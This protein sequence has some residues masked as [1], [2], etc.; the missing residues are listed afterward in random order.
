MDMT[1]LKSMYAHYTVDDPAA[2]KTI[3]MVG[4]CGTPDALEDRDE[5]HFFRTLC[6]LHD[7]GILVHKDFK[8][9]IENLDENYGGR[10]FHTEIEQTEIA[11]LCSIFNPTPDL[12]QH[13][14]DG[15]GFYSISPT[16]YKPREWHDTADKRGVKAIVVFAYDQQVDVGPNVFTDVENSKYVRKGPPP[17]LGSPSI[18]VLK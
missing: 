3:C 15:S 12:G 14:M 7:A 11:V 10:N 6:A 1:S 18:L 9:L 4:A 5:M 13:H 16:H 17:E 2:Y 8:I